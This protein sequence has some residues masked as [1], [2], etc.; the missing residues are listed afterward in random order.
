MSPHYFGIPPVFRICLLSLLIF[1]GAAASFANGD[2]AD[3]T[4]CFWQRDPEAEFDNEGRNHC[5]P[6]AIA[7]G[8]VYLAT[9][10]GFDDVCDSTDHDGQ[11][12]LITELAEEV[13]TDPAE[14]TNPDKILTGLVSYAE[15]HGYSFERLE[16]ASW[17]GVSA[18]NK[19][20]KIAAK[21]SLSWM[22][23]A[24]ED[25]DTIEI[26]N[27]GWYKQEDDG[28]YTRH[29]GHC[30]NVVGAGA[31]S[32]TFDIHNPLLPPDRQETATR[33]TLTPLDD[34]FAV[35]QGSGA[36]ATMAGYFSAVGPGLPFNKQSV[37][38]AVLDSVILF[39]LKAN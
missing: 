37:S 20:H 27:F 14:G 13:S 9:V 11:V 17:R 4:P 25:P 32:R 24:A 7:D 18:A 8:L 28:S 23:A 10:R 21:P 5:A 2:K 35:E 38:A 36:P 1:G 16:L 22:T 33:I 12:A 19:K 34:D 39:K 3:G 26:M 6:V 31:G 29:S 15:S 30:V